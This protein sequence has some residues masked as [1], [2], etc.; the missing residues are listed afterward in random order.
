MTK[1]EKAVTEHGG[2]EEPDSFAV[3]FEGLWEDDEGAPVIIKHGVMLGS[4]GTTLELAFGSLDTCSFRA[5]S[6]L[7]EG[8]LTAD[9]RILWSDGAVWVRKQCHTASDAHVASESCLRVAVVAEDRWDVACGTVEED[10]AAMEGGPIAASVPVDPDGLAN[11]MEQNMRWNELASAMSEADLQEAGIPVQR[12]GDAEAARG[13]FSELCR[14][15]ALDTITLEKEHRKL[16]IPPGIDMSRQVMLDRIESVLL[17]QQLPLSELMVEC[18]IHKVSNFRGTNGDLEYKRELV[19]RIVRVTCTRAWEGHGINHRQL[20]SFEAANKVVEQC[21]H[22]EVK[23]MAALSKEYTSRGFP[24]EWGVGREDL[25]DRLRALLY[26]DALSLEALQKECALYGLPQEFG[27]QVTDQ[28]ARRVL[29]ERL[30]P[31]RTTRFY[32]SLGLPASRIGSLAR[33][34]QL[35]NQHRQFDAMDLES[36]AREYRQFGLPSMPVNRAECLRRL[37]HATLWAQLPLDELRREWDDCAPRLTALGLPIRV[38]SRRGG[39]IEQRRQLTE[40]LYLSLC[41]EDWAQLGLPSRRL[42]SL[43]AVA[44]LA[45]RWGRLGSMGLM[46]LVGEASAIGMDTA[47]ISQDELRDR[48]RTAATWSE[49]AFG[50]LQ[51]ECRLHNT[52]S[53]ARPHER[54]KL[55]QQLLLASQWKTR[56]PAAPKVPNEHPRRQNIPPPPFEPETVHGDVAGFFRILQLDPRT[57]SAETVRKTFRRL[58]LK[59]HPDKNQGSS[60]VQDTKTFR[61]VLDA[62]EGL[63]KH[64]AAVGGH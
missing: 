53:I 1:D 40:L 5:G 46:D 24:L 2:D 55:V 43:Q 35:A 13:L 37:C 54:D 31:A 36:L 3:A 34:I 25:M 59:H 12:L 7:F 11:F 28:E 16:G 47:G 9:D 30:L 18:R 63:C 56:L 14:V 41:A 58:A 17:W 10:S 62:Y 23:S 38:P 27:H 45:D 21:L 42:E 15:R 64:F 26:W 57:A 22:L 48:L 32:E 8:A 61:D 49:L 4:D 44:R 20:G 33:V 51:K 6:E 52:N 50:E 60:K 29:Q 39:E 19:E